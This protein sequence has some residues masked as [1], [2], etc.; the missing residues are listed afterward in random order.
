MDYSKYKISKTN[1]QDLTPEETLPDALSRHSTI[2]LPI[3]KAVFNVFFLIVLSVLA[4]FVFKS[5]QLQIIR[6]NYFAQVAERNLGPRYPLNS[7]RGIIYDSKGKAVVE[8]LPFFDLVV[9]NSALPQGAEERER[10]INSVASSIKSDP[11]EIKAILDKN[12]AAAVFLVKRDLPKEAAIK[13]EIATPAGFFVVADSRRSYPVGPVWAHILGYTAK[14]SP[15]E[16]KA[17]SDYRLNDSIGRLGLEAYYEK[18]LRGQPRQV[19]LANSPTINDSSQARAGSSLYLEVD[20]E[21]QERLFESVTRVFNSAGVKRGAAVIQNPKTGAVLGLV[22]MPSFDPNIFE[23]Y[24]EEQNSR[25]IAAILENK[26]K[27]LFNKAVGGKYSPGSTIKPLLALAGLKEKVVTDSTTIFAKGSISVRS[28]FDPSVI[29]TFNDW[30]IHGLTDLRKSISDSVDVYYYAL[31]GGY[32]DIAGLGIDKIAFYL[33]SLLADK[34]LDIDLPGE[35]VG[36]VPTPEW[37]EKTKGESW[38]IGDTYNISIGQGDLLVTPLWLNAFVGAIANGG[39][40]LK[41]FLVKEIK[42]P[43][44]RTIRTTEQEVLI[45]LPFD[46]KTIQTVKEGMR[47]TV[48]SG[49]ATILAGLPKPVAAKTGTAQVS[50]RT[51]NSLFTV[52][53]PYED[54][55]FSMTILVEDVSQSQGLAVR[56]A[57]DFLT[58]Y[59]NRQ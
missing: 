54:P 53:G 12:A 7:L 25:K 48:T 6:G 9:L 43:D 17:D 49:T 2:E 56:V 1:G 32:G 10:I 36:F 59:F 34:A 24:F 47:Q 35:A 52:F 5:F 3:G 21:I 55:E 11:E 16:L 38:F 40:I 22:S 33:K 51:L 44:G 29:Y 26:D 20:S 18:E 15:E 39:K 23:K 30:K 37:K 41:P 50:G 57:N 27:P 28:K 4:V 13:L 8:N 42:E 19:L 45:E 46:Q 31:G 14:I 58:W